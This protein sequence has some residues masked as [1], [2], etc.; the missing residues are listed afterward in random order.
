MGLNIILR[1]LLQRLMQI[2]PVLLGISCITFGLMHLTPGDPAEIML[3]ADGIKPTLE[4]TRA[5][6][7]ALGLDGPIHMQFVHWLYRVFHLDL[8][9]SYRSGLPVWE[10]LMSRFP[11]T[12]LL[13]GSS[14]LT[15]ILIA[16]PLG[17]GSALY[18]GSLLDRLG[19]AC[20]LFSVSMPGYWLGLLLIYYGAV[21]LKWFPMMGM[22]GWSSVILPACTLGFGMA[23]IYIRLIRTSLL[24]VLGKLYIKAARA[25]G[26]REWQ[27]IS[28]HALRNALLPSLTLLG[29][30]TGGLLGGSVIVESIFSWPGIGRYA[31]E[32][33]FAKD[34]T[35]IQGYVLIMAVAVVLINVA[36]DLLHQLLNPRIRLR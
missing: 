5:A 17:I 35:V 2:I 25:K 20:A 3:R 19:R 33:I 10:E 32:A 12:V 24:E 11:A 23:G 27:V 31:V 22:E 8:G 15:A 18:P 1:Y 30:H 36:V 4:A 34:Y 13:S 7:H 14:L 9:K 21:K 6:R 28:G 26:L 16:L 29:I